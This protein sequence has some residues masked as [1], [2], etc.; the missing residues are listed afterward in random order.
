MT[1]GHDFYKLKDGKLVFIERIVLDVY[2]A[3]DVG[4]ID[5]LSKEDDNCFFRSNSNDERDYRSITSNE[6]I[7]AIDDYQNAHKPLTIKYTLLSEY[8]Q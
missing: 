8:M 7:K 4:L 2:H 3:L 1:N 6:A 5:E